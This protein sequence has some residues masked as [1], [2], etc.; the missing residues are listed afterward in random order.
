M[1]CYC[2]SHCSRF[3]FTHKLA[4]M[5]N[6]MC[7]IKHVVFNGADCLSITLGSKFPQFSIDGAVAEVR[8]LSVE[9]D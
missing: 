5:S 2:I 6:Y 9:F 4:E 7:R 1:P 3:L 8:E